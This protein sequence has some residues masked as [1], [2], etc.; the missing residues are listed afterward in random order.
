[1]WCSDLIDIP[2]ELE[3]NFLMHHTIR[4]GDIKLGGIPASEHFDGAVTV[5][6]ELE[7][8]D[9]DGQLLV[10]KMKCSS[11]PADGGGF[12]DNYVKGFHPQLYVLARSQNTF[13]QRT[14]LL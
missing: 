2:D 5:S 7:Y 9:K 1:M 8:D 11:L 14:K 12:C 10:N 3:L 4:L 6:V 13:S